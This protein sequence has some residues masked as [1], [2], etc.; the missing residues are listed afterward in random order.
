MS[1]VSVW[2]DTVLDGQIWRLEVQTSGFNTLT[3]LRAACY[4]EAEARHLLVATHKINVGALLIQAWGD[5]SQKLET[6]QP[7][8]ARAV[9]TPARP[10]YVPLGGRPQ[11]GPGFVAVPTPQPIRRASNVY[12]APVEDSAG[13][14]PQDQPPTP[15]TSGDPYEDDLDDEALLGPCTC[16]QAP[17]CLPTCARAGGAVAAA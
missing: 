2:W 8:L 13:L 10:L 7:R 16:G 6:E 1:R 9:G 15:T 3:T 4:R 12:P 17:T 11:L 5:E 14:A